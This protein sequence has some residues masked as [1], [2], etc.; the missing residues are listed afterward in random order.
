MHS[1]WCQPSCLASLGHLLGQLVNLAK[2]SGAGSLRECRDW[3]R[4]GLEHRLLRT[5]DQEA[6]GAG[7]G[8]WPWPD[9]CRI[10]QTFLFYRRQACYLFKD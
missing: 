2:V 9:F 3:G 10:S 8:E 7:V 4:Q 5:E 1:G 6:R